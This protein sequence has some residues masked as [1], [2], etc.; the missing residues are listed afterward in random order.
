MIT[1]TKAR[2]IARDNHSGNHSPLYRFYRDGVIDTY[3]MSLEINDALSYGNA[4]TKKQLKMLLEYIY[5]EGNK[6]R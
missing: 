3:G 1:R 2:L 6:Y 5:V 4:R